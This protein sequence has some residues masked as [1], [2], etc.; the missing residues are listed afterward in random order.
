MNVGVILSGPIQFILDQAAGLLEAKA[1]L[2]AFVAAS[3]LQARRST[4][5]MRQQ[6][7][8]L[9]GKDHSEQLPSAEQGQ[10]MQ[11]TPEWPSSL[12]VEEV[13]PSSSAGV[14]SIVNPESS[15]QVAAYEASEQLDVVVLPH[16][17]DGP[18]VGEHYH[19]EPIR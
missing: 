1:M 8:R 14:G 5:I 6:S 17:R 7:R 9:F 16:V 13:R 3:A 18:A 12:I 10:T 11:D 19:R 15:L 4:S 2:S